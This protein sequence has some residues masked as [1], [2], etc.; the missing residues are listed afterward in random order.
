M[1]LEPEERQEAE[2]I[3]QDVTENRL[4]TL[5][6]MWWT[7]SG[8]TVTGV[9]DRNNGSIQI[10]CPELAPL[11]EGRLESEPTDETIKMKGTDELPTKP[12]NIKLTDNLRCEYMG[13]TH[14][15]SVPDVVPGEQ[16]LVYRHR[17]DDR[18]FWLPYRD[19]NH[20]RKVEHVRIA[21]MNKQH[22]DPESEDETYFLEIDTRYNPGIRMKTSN[23]RGES[24]VYTW[25][26]DPK[27]GN[28][29]LQ[30][31]NGNYIYLES[32]SE[33]IQ[34]ENNPGSSCKISGPDIVCEAPGSIT[35]KAP[36]I[37]LKSP[38]ITLDG[39][40]VITKTLD[41]GGHASFPSHSGFPNH[42]IGI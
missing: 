20:L 32:E 42:Y 35:H 7:G 19:N 12:V 26:I 25:E 38:S 29:R 21:M 28:F 2:N 13:D 16:V 1:T 36:E 6:H 34:A 23:A 4:G 11:Q 30:D 8:I 3:A 41:T 39:P 31:D 40:V 22:Q 14:S 10:Y 27:A 24:Y 18:Y 37:T 17:G 5:P 33:L 15:L 9:E